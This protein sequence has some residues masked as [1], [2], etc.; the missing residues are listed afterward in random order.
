MIF[1]YIACHLLKFLASLLILVHN[2]YSVR[3]GLVFRL[4][5]NLHMSSV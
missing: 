2:L 3:L 4:V 5:A 1:T